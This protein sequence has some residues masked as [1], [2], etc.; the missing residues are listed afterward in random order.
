M[1]YELKTGFLYF[2]QGFKMLLHPGIR[3]F[4]IIPFVISAFVF[5]SIVGPTAYY[6]EGLLDDLIN[7][8]PD[9]LSFIYWIITPLL[10]LLFLFISAYLFSLV[11]NIIGAPFNS[12][13]AEKTETLLTGKHSESITG[14][15]ELLSMVQHSLK[16][17][18]DKLV[19]YIPR[20]LALVVLTFIPGVN[21]LASFVWLIMGAWMLAIQYSDF[22]MD[23][24]NINFKNMLL[25]LKKERFTALGF[26]LAVTLTLSI[27][28][29]N[30]LVMP[31]A[32]IGAT[33]MW[34]D[35]H[36]TRTT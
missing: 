26:G 22:A 14:L 28:L 33:I 31:T 17:E 30:F 6:F 13:L 23:N 2:F 19:Y 11:A 5:I 24:N 1:L 29:L 35:L 10:T 3:A 9:W 27:P 36:K 34:V 16:R 25:L 32:V 7:K 12:F 20:L 15:G 8:L 18:L 4:V 21:V